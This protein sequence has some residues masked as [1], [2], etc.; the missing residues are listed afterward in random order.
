[1][2]IHHTHPFQESPENRDQVRRLR[3]R[4]GGTVTLWTAGGGP[5]S[6]AGLTVS[7]RMIATGDPGHAL[8]LI[9]P[10][11]AFAEAVLV[12]R[13]CVVQLLT[14]DQRG[15]A[16]AFGGV[17]PAPGGAFRLGEW[18]DSAWGPVLDGVS[19]WAGL[20]LVEGDPVAVGWSILVDGLIEQVSVAHETVD[21]PL[22]HL[23]GRY[24]P[25]RS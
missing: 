18:A 16:D 6:P 24:Q 20:R 13:R 7:S 22:V 19:G 15:L 17:A 14:W 4:L 3:A 11:S 12:T 9:D 2:T 1:M 21:D 5:V 8:A 10:E 25:P 23:R